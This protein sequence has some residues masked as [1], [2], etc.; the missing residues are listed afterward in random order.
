[1]PVKTILLFVTAFS[2]CIFTGAGAM[3]PRVN[4][5]DWYQYRISVSDW[6]PNKSEVTIS[7]KI[8]ALSAD[9]SDLSC[10]I[11]PSKSVIPI[12]NKNDKHFVKLLRKG[13]ATVFEQSFNIK[14]GTSVWL[15][16]VIRGL[17]DKNEMLKLVNK[18]YAN[19]PSMLAVMQNEVKELNGPI[20]IG[21]ILPLLLRKDNALFA[22]EETAPE[23]ETF[24]DGRQ[25]YVWNPKTVQSR[26]F[27]AESLRAFASFT[28]NR[29]Y[30]NAKKIGDLIIN[31]M[32]TGNKPLLLEKG[33]GDT[34]M[35]PINVAKDLINFNIALLNAVNNNTAVPIEENL[36]N[37]KDSDIKL[38]S[39][40]NLATIY[41]K[42]GQ[43][44]K[45]LEIFE[46]L[47]NALPGWQAVK[48]K[49]KELR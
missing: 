38:M 33:N 23:H 43:K 13:E 34:F 22:V 5:P 42:L 41:L 28:S 21:K 24:E 27:E 47:R 39:E 17:P 4:L 44:E 9:I 11:T 37:L 15:D 26:G 36:K 49:S 10:N 7:T 2:L 25:Y 35:I 14:V 1:M 29:N 20:Y 19:N 32:Q 18:Q 16:A 40:Y 46:K 12:A 45:A 3:T 48:E 8:T 30:V 6:N 31:R